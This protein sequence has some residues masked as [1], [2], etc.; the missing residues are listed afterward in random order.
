M[1]TS[2]ESRASCG[3]APECP[4]TPLTQPDDPPR[5]KLNRL[6]TF[7]AE[8]EA[9]NLCNT[10]CLHCPHD[11]MARPRGRMD[12]QT[13]D[14]IVARFREHLHGAPY[15]LSFSGMGEPLLNPELPRFIAHVAGEAHTSFATNGALLDERRVH[16]LIAAGLDVLHVSFNGDTDERYAEVMGRLSFSTLTANLQQAVQLARGTRLK[17]QA[18]IN[19]SPQNRSHLAAI[20]TR[21]EDVGVE[22]IT[23][24]LVHSRGGHLADATLCDTP[25]SPPELVTCAVLAHTLFVDWRG[26]VFICDHDICGEHTLGDLASEGLATV[27]ERRAALLAEPLPFEIC[28]K[29]QDL[30]KGGF[31]L[32]ERNVGGVLSDWV[33]ALH[34]P[35]DAPAFAKATPAQRWMLET[36]RRADR[37]DRAV[38]RLLQIEASLQQRLDAME[39]NRNRLLEEVRRRDRYIAGLETERVSE[40]PGT[41]RRWLRHLLD[42][43]G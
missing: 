26:R 5:R 9:T 24:S 10:R 22:T 39:D 43:G 18:N 32:F 41:I 12:W 13:Y 1:R 19:V 2:F 14:T 35:A 23:Y 20:R 16:A 25:A 15:S 37:L 17:I 29:C 6:P 42:A 33:Q 21:L 7:H 11:A 38:D 27:L 30:N 31:E 28:R 34:A 4:I 40:K 3:S 8:I 36:Y